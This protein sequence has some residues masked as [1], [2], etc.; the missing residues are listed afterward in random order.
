MWELVGRFFTA[1]F[2][3]VVRLLQRASNGEDVSR[4]IVVTEVA[5]A[6]FAGLLTVLLGNAVGIA[7]EWLGV[8]AGMSGYLGTKAIDRLTAVWED[9]M[10][11]KGPPDEQRKSGGSSE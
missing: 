2:G 10:P 9:R 8:M 6:G 11:G 4:I 5:V 3:G 7:A 1:V